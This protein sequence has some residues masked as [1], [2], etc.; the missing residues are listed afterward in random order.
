MLTSTVANQ[1]KTRG[2]KVQEEIRSLARARWR[3][4]VALSLAVFVMYFGFILAVAFAREAMGTEITIGLTW[5]IVLGALVIVGAWLTTWVY[6]AWAN[7][8]FDGR[9]SEIAS[10]QEQS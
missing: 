6:V 8:H 5:G 9:R 1:F 2:A 7:R 10:R 4:A 3:V